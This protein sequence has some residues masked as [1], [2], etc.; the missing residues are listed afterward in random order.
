MKI[1][2]VGAEFFPRERTD[3]HTHTHDEV[4]SN[5]RFSQFCESAYKQDTTVTLPSGPA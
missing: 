1:R 5:S 3:A 2:R 4:M